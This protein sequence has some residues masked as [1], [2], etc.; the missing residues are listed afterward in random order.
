MMGLKHSKNNRG[1]ECVA[2][3]DSCGNLE[4]RSTP[5]LGR[6]CGS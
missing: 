6:N 2:L 4:G 3:K 5:L 1:G